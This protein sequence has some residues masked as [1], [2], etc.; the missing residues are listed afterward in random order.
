MNKIAIKYGIYTGFGVILFMLVFYFYDKTLMRSPEVI[1]STMILYLAGMFWA[2]MKVHRLEGS[3]N[4]SIGSILE[5]TKGEEKE[6]SL[7]SLV[8]TPFI[9]FLITNAYYA[10]F[11]YWIMNVFDVELLQIHQEL[12]HQEML[13][14]HKGTDK[15]SEVRKNV[16]DDYTPTLGATFT[17]Y[18]IGAIGGF[19]LSFLMALIVRRT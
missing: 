18:M 13:D 6:S 5:N 8:S 7:R 11:F 10:L 15:I 2:T 12:T 4:N 17:K 1:W 9:V 19:I 3:S 14:F 16:L